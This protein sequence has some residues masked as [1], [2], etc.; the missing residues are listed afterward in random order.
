MKDKL[1]KAGMKQYGLL[2]IIEKKL[3]RIYVIQSNQHML[4]FEHQQYKMHV[5]YM[6]RLL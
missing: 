2:E 1:K 6:A 3:I 4:V 5:L